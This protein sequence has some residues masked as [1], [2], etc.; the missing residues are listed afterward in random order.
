MVE[1]VLARDRDIQ[2][3]INYRKVMDYIGD[4]SS[5]EGLEVR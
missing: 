5:Q 4:L 3:V 2:E 1:D